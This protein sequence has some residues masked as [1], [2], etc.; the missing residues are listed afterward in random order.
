MAWIGEHMKPGTARSFVGRLGTVM[1]K[2]GSFAAP[3]LQKIGHW[4]PV[5]GNVVST[6]GMATGNPVIAL[7]AQVAG[8][9]LGMLGGAASKWAG[10]AQ[11]A[12]STGEAAQT[13]TGIGL[14]K[15]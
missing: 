15:G 6:I 12:K 11:N 2:V 10:Y 7:G 3:I 9:G 4:A 14:K 5:A 8:R 13:I 1:K